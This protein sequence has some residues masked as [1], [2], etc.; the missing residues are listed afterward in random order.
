MI[1]TAN[2]GCAAENCSEVRY[3]S[4]LRQAAIGH[5]QKRIEQVIR[6]KEISSICVA[7]VLASYLGVVIQG[8]SVQ[9]QDGATEDVLQ[10]IVRLT[11]IMLRAQFVS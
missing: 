4:Q 1:S 3:V 2:L 5:I 7:P 10:N 6:Q 9:A 8:M 11:M